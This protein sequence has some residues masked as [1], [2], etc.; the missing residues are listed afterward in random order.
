MSVRTNE[1]RAAAALRALATEEC[2]LPDAIRWRIDSSFQ[3]DA[4]EGYYDLDGGDRIEILETAISDMVCNLRHLADLAGISYEAWLD[5]L[6]HADVDHDAEVQERRP[7]MS[8]LTNEV[9]RRTDDP[10]S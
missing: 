4:V 3:G 2:F 5:I 9:V 7:T 1:D 10:F 8:D 6:I